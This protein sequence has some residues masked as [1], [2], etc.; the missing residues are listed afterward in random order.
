MIEEIVSY[1]MADIDS[2]MLLH[3][4]A[5]ILRTLPSGGLTFRSRHWREATIRRYG[6]TIETGLEKT[7]CQ[8][9]FV[10]HF[11]RRNARPGAVSFVLESALLHKKIGKYDQMMEDM[12]SEAGVLDLSYPEY[13]SRQYFKGVKDVQLLLKTHLDV[14][15][16]TVSA[17]R[18]CQAV[19]QSYR[20]L[21]A[22]GLYAEALELV[23]VAI[24]L[25][26]EEYGEHDKLTIAV[27]VD[28]SELF[29]LLGKDKHAETVLR[30]CVSNS[31][32]RHFKFLYLTMLGVLCRR[33]NQLD[34]AAVLLQKA[35]EL[36]VKEV[37][38]DIVAEN[39]GGYD[40]YAL[41]Q[42]AALTLQMKDYAKAEVLFRQLME[43]RI[44]TLS[45]QHPYTLSAKCSV[46]SC[47]K[48]QLHYEEAF[49]IYSSALETLNE[50][51]GSHHPS[52]VI[53]THSTAVAAYLVRKYSLCRTL[54][55]SCIDSLVE[56]FGDTSRQV[57]EAKKLL[58]MLEGKS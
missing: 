34:V 8:S 13:F 3:A 2:I 39:H 27:C 58:A 12:F 50:T 51:L 20:L 28:M 25:Y 46:A 23:K 55:S 21:Y 31:K 38:G 35:R 11:L 52:T 19:K 43:L 56:Y 30:Q 16:K 54:E 26:S 53:T 44:N 57:Q 48:S 22:V 41:S 5:P 40:D 42:L 7:P 1:S 47:L 6:T 32:K 4:I 36:Q 45:E 24:R 37:S 49:A 18:T 33:T 14:L 29:T 15:A 17:E 10:A 9:S